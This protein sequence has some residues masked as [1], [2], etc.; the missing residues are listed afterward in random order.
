MWEFKPPVEVLLAVEAGVVGVAGVD[1]KVAL[2]EIEDEEPLDG[3]EL[4]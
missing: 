4:D 1:A 2:V 3:R